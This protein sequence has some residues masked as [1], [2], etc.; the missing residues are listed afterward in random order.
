MF[1]LYQIQEEGWNRMLMK[2]EE[3]LPKIILLLSIPRSKEADTL[4]AVLRNPDIALRQTPMHST[5]PKN[6]G[7]SQGEV[8]EDPTP[9]LRV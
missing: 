7:R 8:T 4:A 6:I 5:H 1:V 3:V 9:N 2:E